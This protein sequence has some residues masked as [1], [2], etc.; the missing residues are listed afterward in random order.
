MDGDGDADLVVAWNRLIDRERHQGWTVASNDGLGG[1]E[2]AQEVTFSTTSFSDPI[3][4][5][6]L[7]G[8]DFDGDG[9]LDLVVAVPA[10][11]VELWYNWGDGFDPTL[12][13][14]RVRLVGLADGDGDGGCGPVGF[15][16]LVPSDSVDQ[17]RL[18][19]CQQ[20]GIRL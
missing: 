17:R 10:V 19:L 9:L 1:F 8:S 14:P 5:M 7:Q 2:P 12:Q 13:L 4:R 3:R 15:R 16:L 6:D 20:R 18:R 11:A